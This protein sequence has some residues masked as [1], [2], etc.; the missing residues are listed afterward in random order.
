MY[1]TSSPTDEPRRGAAQLDPAE[2]PESTRVSFGPVP[3]DPMPLVYH[4]FFQNPN[5]AVIAARG[6]LVKGI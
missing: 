2:F 1:F 4:I 3:A 5:R 6:V